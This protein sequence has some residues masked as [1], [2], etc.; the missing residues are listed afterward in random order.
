MLD[1]V[2][3]TNKTVKDPKLYFNTVIASIT[4]LKSFVHS[5]RECFAVY[6]RSGAD[7]SGTAEYMHA[8]PRKRNVRLAPLDYGREPEAQMTPSQMFHVENFRSI[9][10]STRTTIICI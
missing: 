4:S 3:A 1:Q 2:N 5:Q 7:I 8:R 6:E 9:Y 10:H